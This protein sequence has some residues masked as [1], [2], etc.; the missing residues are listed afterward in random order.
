MVMLFLEWFASII[1]IKNKKGQ[2][3][4]HNKQN[5]GE[6]FKTYAH[7]LNKEKVVFMIASLRKLQKQWKMYWFMLAS[8]L[9]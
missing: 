3:P 1:R 8:T 2:S 4:I 6:I 9:L 5:K 7:K